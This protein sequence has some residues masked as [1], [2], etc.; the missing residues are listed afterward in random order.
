MEYIYSIVFTHENV[1]GDLP[2]LVYLQNDSIKGK[3]SFVDI[4]E[5]LRFNDETT[6]PINYDA[7]AED[8]ENT[9]NL[10]ISIAPLTVIVS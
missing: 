10:L 7:S 4:K 6:R 8:M 2:L 5:T 9:L 3:N 1:G